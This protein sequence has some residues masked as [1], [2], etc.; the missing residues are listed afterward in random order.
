MW[1]ECTSQELPAGYMSDFTANRKALLI[2]EDGGVL[3]STPRYGINQ[4]QQIRTIHAQLS[5]DGDL[6]I[7]SNTTL[8]GVQQDEVSSLV[9]NLSTEK[10]KKYLEKNLPLTTYEVNNFTYKE[11]RSEMPS[12]VEDLDITVNNYASVSGKRIFI[13]PNIFNRGGYQYIEDTARKVDIEFKLEYRDKDEVVIEI[14]EGYEIEARPKD[15]FLKT[16]YGNYMVSSSLKGNQIIYYRLFE[17]FSGRFPASEQTAV[18]DF[19]KTIFKT[20]R[21]KIVLVKKGE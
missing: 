13:V 18:I 21:T 20:D 17:Q 12:I 14:P 8:E 7:K 5:E 1:L 15:I 2:T 19:Y 11:N 3:V 6:K 4:N 9:R 10:I 16:K